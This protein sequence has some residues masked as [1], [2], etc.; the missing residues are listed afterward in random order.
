[1]RNAK[2]WET[3]LRNAGL[4]PKKFAHKV[5]NHTQ[6]YVRGQVQTLNQSHI[7]RKGGL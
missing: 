3:V 7:R 6:E 4:T 2:P 1:M 5:V